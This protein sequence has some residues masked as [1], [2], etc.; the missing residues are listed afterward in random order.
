MDV[1][2]DAWWLGS[3]MMGLRWARAQVGLGA[4]WAS[5]TEDRSDRVG[6]GWKQ[7]VRR[8]RWTFGE[9]RW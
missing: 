1:K 9:L 6:I 8:L 7:L 5:D 4:G 3:D 2:Q